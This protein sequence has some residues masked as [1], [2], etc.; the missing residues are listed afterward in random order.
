[1]N[2]GTI[3]TALAG[4]GQSVERW[5]SRQQFLSARLGFYTDYLDS[6]MLMRAFAQARAAQL[7]K[8]G[9]VSYKAVNEVASLLREGKS[10]A[11]SLK[12]VAPAADVALIQAF[13]QS[14]RL[15]EG[16]RQVVRKV[17]DEAMLLREVRSALAKPAIYLSLALALVTLGIPAM[18]DSIGPLLDKA[19]QTTD[20]RALIAFAAFMQRFGGLLIPLLLAALA[21][22][23]I[24][25]PFWTGKLRKRVDQVSPIHR[26]YRAYQGASFLKVLAIQLSVTPQLD[27]ALAVIAGNS[28]P[29]LRSYI[30]EILRALPHNRTHP[31]DAFDVQLLEVSVID[32][33]TL[34]SRTGTAEE[35]IALRADQSTKKALESIRKTAGVMQQVAIGLAGLLLVWVAISLVLNVIATNMQKLE[36]GASASS[37]VR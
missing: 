11:Q 9:D 12:P 8:R 19:T 3:Q 16:F 22:M 31:M 26:M 10:V 1:M 15:E 5:W 21:A 7:K 33:L 2:A 14:N 34:I 27:T 36:Q 4:V 17:E 28:N 20:Q 25:L 29:W 37:R 6:R 13:E 32:S 30:A 18:V 35:A 24:S 23:V